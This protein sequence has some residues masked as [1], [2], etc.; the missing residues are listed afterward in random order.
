MIAGPVLSSLHGAIFVKVSCPKLINNFHV[1][2]QLMKEAGERLHRRGCHSANT[3]GGVSYQDIKM[4][5][6]WS[7]PQGA[8]SP[9]KCLKAFTVF[10]FFLAQ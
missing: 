5:E 10:K 3:F 1:D 6:A 7:C 4:I 8:D 2:S 9:E